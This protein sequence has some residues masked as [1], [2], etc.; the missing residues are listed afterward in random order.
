MAVDN[1][2]L[3]QDVTDEINE[4][5]AELRNY[6]RTNNAIKERASDAQRSLI[7]KGQASRKGRKDDM[8]EKPP[9]PGKK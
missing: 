8:A 2:K 9:M 7:E 1:K 4:A 3:N 5:I 6:Q